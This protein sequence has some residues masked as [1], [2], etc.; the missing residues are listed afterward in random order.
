MQPTLA[1]LRRRLCRRVPRGLARLPECA[2]RGAAVSGDPWS[3]TSHRK[4][5]GGCCAPKGQHSPA[6]RSKQRH[7]A[8]LAP[9]QGSI[10]W[11]AVS[12]QRLWREAVMNAQGRQENHNLRCWL[13]SSAGERMTEVSPPPGYSGNH[14]VA[15]STPAVAKAIF[16]FH[17]AFFWISLSSNAAPVGTDPQEQF[18]VLHFLRRPLYS[19]SL[20]ARC[21]PHSKPLRLL[22]HAAHTPNSRV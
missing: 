14:E 8:A 17:G 21:L 2:Q 1:A 12:V 16:A 7:L 5:A 19:T 9:L 4:Q 15:G 3:C 18:L 13:L 10:S 6:G 20:P 22:L 11:H